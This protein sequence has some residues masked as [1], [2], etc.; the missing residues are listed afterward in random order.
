[1]VWEGESAGDQVRLVGLELRLGDKEGMIG[2]GACDKEANRA[3]RLVGE[4]R[5]WGRDEQ[6]WAGQGGRGLECLVFVGWPRWGRAR[7]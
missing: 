4:G 5:R 1:M 3:R 6:L 7:V 2:D